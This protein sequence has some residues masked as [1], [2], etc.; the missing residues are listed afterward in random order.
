LGLLAMVEHYDMAKT[1]VPAVQQELFVTSEGALFAH[2]ASD[3][4]NAAAGQ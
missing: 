4:G 3:A 2:S 1:T